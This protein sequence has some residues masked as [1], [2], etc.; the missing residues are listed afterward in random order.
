MPR[1]LCKVAYDGA[2]FSGWQSQ[3]GGGSVQDALEEAL[4]R[5][6]GT[7]VR[8]HGAGRTDAGVHALGQCFHFDAPATRMTAKDWTPALNSRLPATIRILVARC[9][10][11]DF[12]ARFSAAGKIYRYR[13]RNARI[14]PP[15]EAGR[16][17]L[18]PQPLDM[19]SLRKAAS[20]FLGT[21]DFSGFSANRGSPVSDPRR[22]LE[23]L[24]ISRR[25][26]LIEIRL[27]GTGFLYKMARMITAALIECAL[28]KC[29][30]SRLPLIL[31]G[32]APRW[33]RVAPAAGLTLV[34]V[35]YGKAL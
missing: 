25:G 6:V 28:Q 7:P 16:S 11:P 2:A 20:A 4:A 31:E 29:D 33:T 22:T 15:L 26:S 14:L 9:V 18:V 19:D 32:Q 13:I 34:K 17:W 12:H 27:Q 30:A 3:A 1:L 24:S 5:V 35:L 8:I 23:A 21:H 10:P